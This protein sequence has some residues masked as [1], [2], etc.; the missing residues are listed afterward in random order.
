VKAALAPLGQRGEILSNVPFEQV[1]AGFESAAI[2]LVPSVWDEPFGRTAIEAMAGGAALICSGRG[3]LGEVIGTDSDAA[4]LRVEPTTEAIS[5][6]IERLAGDEMA[7]T[8][9][10]A[11]G[12]LRARQQF[13]IQRIAA[14][15]D[16]HLERIAADAGRWRRPPGR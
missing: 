14:D 10:A 13:S 1:K 11:A 16:G 8:A 12:Q 15:Y 9:L 7:R 5:R 6:A 3:G 2:A 4:A